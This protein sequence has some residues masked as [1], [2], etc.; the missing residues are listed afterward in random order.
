LRLADGNSLGTLELMSIRKYLNPPPMTT[1]LIITHLSA[2]LMGVAIGWFGTYMADKSTDLR[3]SKEKKNA[4]NEAWRDV[5]A[6]MPDLIK[7]MQEDWTKPENQL[8]RTFFILHE[9]QDGALITKGGSLV[10]RYED[11]PGLGDKMA[12]LEDYGFITHV[13]SEGVI[14]EYRVSPELVNY[15]LKDRD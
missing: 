8:I 15:L 13:G 4:E 5:R 10:Y 14:K 12:I 9:G 2:L 3:R 6:K 7:E 1:T 11:H